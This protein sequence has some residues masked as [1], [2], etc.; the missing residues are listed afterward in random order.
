MWRFGWD[1]NKFFS[2]RL[3]FVT[4]LGSVKAILAEID[5]NPIVRPG[6]PENG[7]FSSTWTRPNGKI[8]DLIVQPA[9][10]FCWSKHYNWPQIGR[11]AGGL[12]NPIPSNRRSVKPHRFQVL[13]FESQSRTRKI[14]TQCVTRW[15]AAAAVWTSPPPRLISCGAQRHRG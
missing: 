8:G 14:R 13:F 2:S 3:R 7:P 4:Y 5:P 1:W 11:A 15:R 10:P 12:V 9:H 6:R